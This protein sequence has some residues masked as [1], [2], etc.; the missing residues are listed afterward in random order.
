MTRREPKSSPRRNSSDWGIASAAI[1]VGLDSFCKIVAGGPRR[2]DSGKTIRFRES[3]M[4]RKDSATKVDR[5]RFLAGVAITGAAASAVTTPANAVT[6]TAQAKRLPSSLPPSAQ[7]IAAET[8][9]PQALA[10]ATRP[11]G[12]DFMVDVIKTLDI[13]YLPSNAASSFRGLH[14]SLINYGHNKKPEFLTVNHEGNRR[15]HGAWLF[16]GHR[17]AADDTGARFGRFPEFRN[18]ASRTAPS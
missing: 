15:C 9:T 2:Q 8:G 6:A 1:W 12:S 7:A 10:R 17:Q 18:P 3:E 11:D 5:R 4:A 14:E 16:Q 13:E